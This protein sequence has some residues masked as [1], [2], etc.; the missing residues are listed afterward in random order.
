MGF[1]AKRMRTVFF[2]SL[3]IVLSVPRTAW[4]QKVRTDSAAL[5]DFFEKKIRPLLA[6]NCYNCHSANTNSNGG[7]RVDDRNGL[8]LGGGRGPAIV[9]GHPEKSLLLQAVRHTHKDVKMPPKKHLSD[10]Q[11]A[12]LTQWIKD[13][14][15]WP[16]A[17]LP[18]SVAKIDPAYAKLRKEHWAWQPL[19]QVKSPAVRDTAWPRSDID[20]FILFKL[21]AK[22][23]RPVKD[24]DRGDLI[25]RVTF[26]LPPLPS[27]PP[28]TAPFLHAP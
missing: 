9:P 25:R 14:A 3:A 15:A 4:S 10:Q 24:A 11:I 8:I 6:D 16:K 20:R 21:E 17:R 2:L 13:G 23:L 18:A 26:D 1:E 28:Q 19:R 27:P 5:V 12:D 7:L 22:G